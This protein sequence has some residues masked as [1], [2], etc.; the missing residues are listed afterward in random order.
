MYF[1][2]ARKVALIFF[3][4]RCHQGVTGTRSHDIDFTI[5]WIDQTDAMPSPLGDRLHYTV[6]NKQGDTVQQASAYAMLRLVRCISKK[7]F[8]T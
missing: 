6:R 5:T 1:D 2:L 7:R 3:C 4:L 8:G